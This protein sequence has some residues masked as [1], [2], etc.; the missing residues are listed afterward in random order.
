[1]FKNE[2]KSG[3]RLEKPFIR[4]N[5][6]FLLTIL[7][8]QNLIKVLKIQI[9]REDFCPIDGVIHKQ[10]TLAVELNLA[11]IHSTNQNF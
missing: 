6:L 10:S 9:K 5:N 2:H 11:F 4:D 3:L 8:G 1:M 7:I